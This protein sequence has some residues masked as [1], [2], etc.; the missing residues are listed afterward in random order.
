[1]KPSRASA[2]LE[3]QAKIDGDVN[4]SRVSFSIPGQLQAASLRIKIGDAEKLVAI[5]PTHRPALREL[6]AAIQLPDYLKREPLEET[7]RGG[8]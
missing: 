3:H 7:V 8:R 6:S 4:N 1:M 5:E 2:R